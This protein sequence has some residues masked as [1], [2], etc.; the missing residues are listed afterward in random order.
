MK[1]KIWTWEKSELPTA[2]LV[3]TRP[4][5]CRSIKSTKKAKVIFAKGRVPFSYAK[6][7]SC[8]HC[9]STFTFP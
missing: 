2:N 4:L 8:K 7:F 5:D 3:L 9:F 6:D 1:W